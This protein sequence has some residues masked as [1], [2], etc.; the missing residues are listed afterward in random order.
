M[1]VIIAAGLAETICEHI[2]HLTM[3][4]NI[5]ALELGRPSSAKKKV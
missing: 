4:L 2:K 5:E 1:H 3:K